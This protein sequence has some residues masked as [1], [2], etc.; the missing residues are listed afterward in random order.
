MGMH[1]NKRWVSALLAV[2]C[3]LGSAYAAAA[4]P[5]PTAFHA[6]VMALS[7]VDSISLAELDRAAIATEDAADEGRGEPPRYAIPRKVNITP[8][9]DGT[10]ESVDA[11]TKVWR[12]VVKTTDA[13]SLNFGFT[14][15]FLPQGSS[16]LLYS[17]DG[18]KTRG[19]FTDADNRPYKE[20][21]TPVILS[22]EVVIELTIPSAAIAQL[23][24]TIGQIGQ[25]YR[26]FG[27]PGD[28]SGSCNMDVACLAAADPWQ[29]NVRAVAV[30][31]TGG[32]R[33]CTGS[34][35][36][37]TAGD[38]KMYFIT[39]HHCSVAGTAASLVT[40][41]SY[42]NSICRL[43]GSAASGA[44]GDG[45]LAQFNTG[46]TLRAD[47]AP[48]DFT[49]VEMTQAPNPAFNLFWEGWDHTPYSSTGGPGNGDFA[50]A[51]GSLCAAIH[52]PNTDEKRIT[53]SA[54]N[55]TTTS[56]NVATIPGDGTH[57]HAFW[58]PMPVF[59]PNPS[60]SIP[61]GVTEP[62]SSGSPL[63]N[64]QRRYIGQLHGGPSACGATG[65]NLSDYYGHF[66]VSWEGGGTSATRTKDWLDAGA[67]GVAAIDGRN[68]CTAPPVPANLVATVNGN[69]KIDLT[70]DP[71]VGANSYKVY[72][73]DGA[74]PGT[75][76]QLIADNVATTTYSDTTVSG[77]ATYSY[78]VTS[79]S[80]AQTCE[81]THSSCSA[82]TA[83]GLCTLAPTFAGLTSAASS[84]NSV[85]GVDLGWSAGTNRCAGGAVKYNIFRST[86]V[87]FTPSAGNRIANC[88]TGTSYHDSGL[89]NATKYYYV[90][91]AEDDTS[92]GGGSCN[93]GNEDTNTAQKSA[94]PAGAP[95]VSFS[96]D[97]ESG[98]TN[99]TLAGTGSGAKF[100]QVTSESH[101]STHSWFS[102]DTAA[103]GDHTI[104]STNA[105]AVGAGA[106]LNFWH[107]Y[108][109]EST[110]DG[111]VLEYFL[112]GTTWVDILAASGSVPANANRFT[113]GGYN[114]TISTQYNSPI[115]GRKAWSGDSGAFVQGNV[116]LA[117]FGGQNVYFRW[118]MASDS[119]VAGTGYS[120]DDVSIS[121][122]TIC[123][124]SEIIFQD[125][126]E[127][128]TP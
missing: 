8:S 89:L 103:V 6:R 113:S 122:G 38:T 107:H 85:C 22:P 2:S 87:G 83:T 47:Y 97:M 109:T 88:Q 13:S 52:H 3:C 98:T 46:A 56:Y 70:W 7:K 19:P 73:G 5:V 127:V 43:P 36:N 79:Y 120:L 121:A 58:D 63:Y 78:G 40:Y 91:R 69:N 29:D 95:T 119:S 14:Q 117:D 96:D 12:Y 74:C 110:Y 31:S 18:K 57:V 60:T 11:H 75:N 15:F 25:G 66:S 106:T 116:D 59:P 128:P 86:T 62:G 41:W 55:T 92:N 32:S 123:H 27:T 102:P 72:R 114:A 54:T 24:L 61:P 125:G 20:L 34:L 42:Q 33:F 80:T 101:S 67:I 35:I 49:L 21:W 81:S 112:D 111:A 28:K 9:K 99:W 93:S 108:N 94:I 68:Q 16:L 126:F 45:S 23:E 30:I 50:C 51:P 115:L 48:S 100:A 84:A 37:D 71:A 39:A 90:A 53:F 4:D 76:W 105:I 104:A 77:S 64:A 118:R 26:G 65:A 10:W 1:M 124:V 82:A 44:T 17:P